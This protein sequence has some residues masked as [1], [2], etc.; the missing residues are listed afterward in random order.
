MLCVI[1]IKMRERFCSNFVH[2]NRS[3]KENLGCI[4]T[5]PEPFGT[6]KKLI[7][8]SLAFIRDLADPLLIGFPVWYQMG[9]LMKV[10]QFGTVQFQ[11]GIVPV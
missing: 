1:E 6:G 9:S 10:I 4:Y 11:D 3:L 2:N 7:L 8:I 5:R